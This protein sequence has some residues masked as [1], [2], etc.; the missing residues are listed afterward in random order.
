MKKKY[1]VSLFPLLLVAQYGVAAQLVAS[2]T[3]P[4]YFNQK[5]LASD[6]EGSLQGNVSFAQSLT[7]QTHNKTEEE[8]QPHLVSLRRAL[9][10]FEPHDLDFVQHGKITATVK[11]KNNDV[12][13]ETQMRTPKQL[14]RIAGN[15]GEPLDLTPPDEYGLLINT[16]NAI[17]DVSEERQGAEKLK[18]LLIENDTV[19]ISTR[20]YHWARDFVLL[21]DKALHNKL[22]TFSSEAA[23]NSVV[24]LSGRTDII[25][26]GST[27]TYRNIDGAWYGTNDVSINRMAYSDKA[28]SAIL[29]AEVILPGFSITFVS[30]NDEQGRISNIKVGSNPR[31]IFNTIDIGMLTPP[32][33]QYV[34]MKDKDLHRQYFQNIQL[35]ELIVNPYESVHLKEI[36]FPDGKKIQY[37]DMGIDGVSWHG[38]ESNY[39]IARELISSG[40]NTA[41]YGINSSTVRPDIGYMID[42]IYPAAQITLPSAVGKYRQG[43]VAHGGMGSYKGVASISGGTGNEFTHEIGHELGVGAHYPGGFSRAAHQP[44]TS[45]NSAWGWDADKDVFIPNFA[46]LK[47]GNVSCQEEQCQPPFNGHSFSF[48]TMSG[49]QPAYKHVNIY[50]LFTPY[51]SSVF[52]DFLENKANFDPNSPS[53]FSLWDKAAQ[54]MKPW[55]N[56]ILDDVSISAVVSPDETIGPDEYGQNSQKFYE[57]FEKGNLVYL[58]IQNNRWVRDVYLPSSPEFEGKT[59]VVSVTSAWNSHLHFDG[60]SKTINRGD[61]ALGLLFNNGQ[62]IETDIG[63]L[64]KDQDLIPS[65]QGVAVTTLVGYY[66]PEKTLPAYIYPAL[67]GAYGNTY[68]DQLVT[69]ACQLNVFSH[70]GETQTFNLY[71]RRLQ[72]G[73]MNRFHVNIETALQPYKAEVSCGGDIVDSRL[74]DGPKKPLFSNKVSTLGGN[75]PEIKGVE[76]TRVLKG[77]AFSPMQGVQAMDDYDGDVSSTLTVTGTVDTNTVGTYTLTYSAND[78]DQ[79]VTTVNRTVLVEDVDITPPEGEYPDYVAGHPYN[80]GDR[81]IATDGQIYQC[82][83]FPNGLWC[84][85]PAYE[86]AVSI[87]WQEA[88]DLVSVSK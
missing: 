9:L 62:W 24:H 23:Q 81:V 74:L 75:A 79:Q 66:D 78:S 58:L 55:T 32:R 18:A 61:E 11:N 1:L 82:R 13:F 28:F 30:E 53:G 69:S 43:I 10:M 45:Y 73:F 31:L 36:M 29:P 22:I 37:M 67:H 77:E 26:G 76:T 20:N 50:T 83:S 52:Q 84:A 56:T 16:N 65:K 85:N 5:S 47:T 41:N 21:E 34:F 17:Q 70:K 64:T 12:V 39:R 19:H 59:L 33:D 42:A 51:E 35:S 57:L 46:R 7:M 38:S 80:E 40:I 63:D 88:W 54:E 6:T 27:F 48:G 71:N 14:T 3:Q 68:Q 86:P 72:P 87:Y 4:I 15:L 8:R 49:G 60:Q 25:Y 44:S 2:D